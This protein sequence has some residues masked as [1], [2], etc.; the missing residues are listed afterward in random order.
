MKNGMDHFTDMMP[1][2]H[3]YV[4]VD[5]EA[6]L[7]DEKRLLAIYNICKE[8]LTKDPGEDAESHAAKL[9]EVVLLQCSGK[10]IMQHL[11]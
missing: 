7:S 1:P 8:M 4:T 3:N 2:L 10:L 11:C 9:L 6:F 5:T